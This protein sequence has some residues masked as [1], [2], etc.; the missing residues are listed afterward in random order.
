MHLV[1]RVWEN[2]KRSEKYAKENTY[3]EINGNKRQIIIVCKDAIV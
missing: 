3:G 2:N 1:Q